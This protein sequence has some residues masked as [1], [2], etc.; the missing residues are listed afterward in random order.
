MSDTNGPDGS[1]RQRP[2]LPGPHVADLVTP[3]ALGALEPDEQALVDRHRRACSACD[4]LLRDEHRFVSLLPLAARATA[5]PPPDVKIALFA[6][7]AHA[8]RATAAATPTP[9]AL[10]DRPLAPAPTIPDSRA[11]PATTLWRRPSGQTPTGRPLPLP[12]W[13]TRWATALLVVP[14]LL[15]LAGTGA[16]AM[17]LRARADDSGERASRYGAIVEAAFATDRHVIELVDGP[18]AKDAKAWIV[19]DATLST[20]T[21]YMRHNDPRSDQ[22]FRLVA[23][24]DGASRLLKEFELDDRGRALETLLLEHPLTDY[25]ALRIKAESAATDADPDLTGLVLRAADRPSA[26]PGAAAN[27]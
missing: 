4:R 3:Y 14:L 18:A 19:A 9:V 26:T 1:P 11:I 5:P 22:R 17:Q 21:F 2:I 25:Q 13:G 16:W 6:R 10:A 27:P 7:V 24:V 15:A 8:Q 23:T 12:S 20:A